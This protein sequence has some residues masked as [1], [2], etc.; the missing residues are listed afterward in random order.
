MPDR[1][2]HTAAGR[3]RSRSRRR[4]RGGGGGARGGVGGG[5]AERGGAVEAERAGERRGVEAEQLV[6]VGGGAGGDG[7][8]AGADGVA[9]GLE[10]GDGAGGV[11]DLEDAVDV[12]DRTVTLL[13]ARLEDDLHDVAPGVLRPQLR[14]CSVCKPAKSQH[15]YQGPVWHRRLR[16]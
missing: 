6:A 9:V 15:Y 8:A 2:A 5:G 3:R 13:P 11:V 4:R 16:F 1:H 14:H 12:A 10:A 7:A